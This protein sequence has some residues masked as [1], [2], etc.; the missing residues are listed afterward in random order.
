MDAGRQGAFK[1]TINRKLALLALFAG[2]STIS[3]AA[4]AGQPAPQAQAAGAT[5]VW[6]HQG[7]DLQ[8]DPAARFGVL[9][10]GMRYLIYRNVTPPGQVAVRF[11]I[12]AGDLMETDEQNGLA[13]F[14]EHMAFNGTTNIPEGE[15]V[16][17][18]E[19]QGLAFGRDTNAFTAP[20]QT[21]YEL[22]IPAANGEKVDTALMIMREVAGE[23]LFGAEAIDRERGI[24]QSEDRSMYAPA[25]RAQ[26]MRDQFLMRGQLV[27]RR[28]DIGSLDV[29]RTA[30]RDRFVDYYRKYYRPERAT[31]VIVGDVDPAEV[32]AKIRS[33]FEGWRNNAPA[34]G[35]PDQGRPAARPFEAGS[36]VLEGAL[37]DVS[38]NYIRPYTQVTDSRAE[39]VKGLRETLALAVLNRRLRRISEGADAP[40]ANAGAFNFDRYQSA[41]HTMIRAEPKPGQYDAATRVLEQEIRRLVEHGILDAELQREIVDMRTAFQTAV[42]GAATRP[43]TQLAGQ[44]IAA[45]NADMAILSPTQVLAVFEEAVRGFDGRTAHQMVRRLL[46]GS[47][48]LLFATSPDA[49]PG[50]HERL[51]Q[52]YSQARTAAVTAPVATAA[53]AWPYTSFGTAGRV[54][55]REEI[56]DLGATRVRFANGVTMI[57]KPTEF[58][59]GR[60]MVNARIGGGRL[61]MGPELVTAPLTQGAFRDGGLEQLNEEELREAL[62]GK[63]T[64]ANFGIGDDALTLGGVTRPEDLAVQMQLLAAYVAHPGWREQAFG[65]HRAMLGNVLGAVNSSPMN[66]TLSQL[67]KL[68]RSGDGRWGFPSAEQL[69]GAQLA[70]LRAAIDPMLRS[71]PLE[72]TVVGNISVDEAIRQASTTFGALPQRQAQAPRLPGAERIA[73]TRASEMARLRHSGRPDVA[74]GMIAWPTDDFYD[75]PA[76]ARAVQMLRAVMQ[77][78]GIDK[79][80]EE[81]GA[82]YSPVV[83]NEASE[84]FDEFGFMM[85]GAEVNPSQLN[86]LLEAVT[87]VAEDLKSREVT[88]DELARAREPILTAL[89]NDRNTNAF[90]LS[91][92]SGATWEPRRLE[93]IRTTEA[94]LRAITPADIRRVAQR[95]LNPARAYRLAV[96]PPAAAPA[97]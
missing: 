66:V 44:F 70:P 24:I 63:V 72:I 81:L 18:L 11:R 15:Y 47:E 88:A 78:R 75:S 53:R 52:A 46:T 3:F 62:A 16:R 34:G 23:I 61:A 28:L 13:H 21:V 84:V 73:F 22:N 69:A 54:V 56:A 83:L 89:A 48:P 39:R 87:E 1:M 51:A 2:T 64:T 65:R 36:A 85:M 12:S 74:F 42:A 14:I 30:P 10:N 86:Q 41:E 96:E 8:P 93:T 20:D 55:E 58:E 77:L 5:R 17:I 71:A 33:R 7:G 76:D 50:G 57:V 90:W 26:V 43:T 97:G 95:Y 91:R 32:E 79:L 60:V 92:L 68:T 40:F 35:E 4:T 82:T 31:L 94:G 25:R 29:I 27:S 45:L 38:V 59:Q 19:R 49:I 67:G 9:P 37:R 80:R 6:P